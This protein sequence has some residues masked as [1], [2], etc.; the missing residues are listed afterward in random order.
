MYGR[1]SMD[2]LWSDF[3]ALDEVPG[4]ALRNSKKIQSIY[5]QGKSLLLYKFT[6]GER[7]KTYQV[8]E[9]KNKKYV[10]DLANTKNIYYYRSPHL[11]R[12]FAPIK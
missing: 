4:N 8:I 5:E 6:N 2:S 1:I 7:K 10:V 11:F 9:F 3:K 12:Y